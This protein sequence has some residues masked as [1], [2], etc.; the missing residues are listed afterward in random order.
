M[1]SVWGPH[2]AMLGLLPALSLRVTLNDVGADSGGLDIQRWILNPG[3]H[4]QSLPLQPFPA[5]VSSSLIPTL[6]R[7]LGG[8]T[9]CFVT[10]STSRLRC[11]R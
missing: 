10:G 3:S 6:Q 7:P 11:L 2:T 9:C 1:G 4:T 8:G 5:S